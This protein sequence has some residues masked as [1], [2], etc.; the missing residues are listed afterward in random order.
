M[1]ANRKLA[2]FG[3]FLLIIGSAG[4]RSIA[5]NP[6]EI[7]YAI[8]M[9]VLENPRQSDVHKRIESLEDVDALRI[10]AFTA[11]SAAWGMEA[12]PDI[13][14]DFTLHEMALAAIHRLF[15][16]DSPKS[17]DAIDGYKKVFCVDG[18]VS[19]FFKEWEEERMSLR[20]SRNSNV[21]EP[22][23]AI[24]STPNRRP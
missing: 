8:A 16:V 14:F 7:S 12:G 22:K 3:C 20:S 2:F 1:K 21:N 19:T 13:A 6:K 24:I 23:S 15:V 11:E 18:S 5:V 9:D 10:I 4:C 17:R